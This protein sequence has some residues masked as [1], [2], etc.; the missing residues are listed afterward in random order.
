LKELLTGLPPGTSELM[1]H[2]GYDDGALDQVRTRLRAARENELQLLT[3]PE[4]AAH[5]RAQAIQLIH[6][7]QLCGQ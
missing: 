3:D 5:L 2:P 4:I 7:G 1:C 6:Y